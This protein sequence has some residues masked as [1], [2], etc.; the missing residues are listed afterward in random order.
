MKRSSHLGDVLM[1]WAGLVAGTVAAGVAHQFGADGVFDHCSSFSP[2]PLLVIELVGIAVAA[3]GGLTSWR[4]LLADSETHARKVVATV[5][6]GAASLFVFA[7]L[8]PII[9]S[10]LI[11][12]CFG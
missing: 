5:S 9:A 1:P 8:L 11:P 6:V 4:V 3:A 10:L 12:P 2:G 7:M